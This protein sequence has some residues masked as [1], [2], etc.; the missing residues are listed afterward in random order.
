[1]T[2]SRRRL[3]LMLAP[4]LALVLAGAPAAAYETLPHS[5]ARLTPDEMVQ[6]IRVHDEP[7]EPHILVTTRKAWP[8]GRALQ[9]A[10][11]ND[12]HLRALVDRGTGAVRWQVWHDLVSTAAVPAF[13]GVHYRAGGVVKETHLVVAEHWEDDCPGVDAIQRAC[14]RYSRY[15]FELPGSVVAEIAAR[16]EQGSRTPWRLRFRDGLGNLVTSGLAP[17]EAAGLLTVVEQVR[18]DTRGPAG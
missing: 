8:K 7:L 18:R 2:V 16:Y 11:A 17:A 15:V 12:V 5:L 4:V 3:A 13:E 14:N 10:H 9:G 6:R 1:M